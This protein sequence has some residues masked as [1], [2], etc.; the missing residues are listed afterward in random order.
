MIRYQYGRRLIEPHHQY[1]RWVDPRVR[2]LRVADVTAYLLHRGWTQVPPDREGFLIFREP[3]AIEVNGGPFYQ[4]VP[5][6]EESD[7]YP[8]RLFEL[9]TGLAE[10]EDRQAS[11]VIDDIQ[12][13][14]AD[15]QPNGATQ[16]SARDSELAS[17]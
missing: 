13:Q 16:A 14:A 4:F 12:R 7:D 1:R 3:S 8:Q 11:A 2:T 5:D 17:K 9:V 6:A 10:A 15:R